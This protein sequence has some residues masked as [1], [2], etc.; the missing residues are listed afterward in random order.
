[1]SYSATATISRG[2]LSIGKRSF[3]GIAAVS[4]VVAAIL[5]IWMLAGGGGDSFSTGQSGSF[6]RTFAGESVPAASPAPAKR[7]GRGRASSGRRGP[8]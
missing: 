6:D 8:R 4:A 2:R 7:R 5:L 3:V 1:M